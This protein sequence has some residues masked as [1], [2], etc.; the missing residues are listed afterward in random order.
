MPRSSIVLVFIA[1]LS[2]A[3]NKITSPDSTE[4]FFS[5]DTILFDTVF[6]SIGSTTKELRV[7]NRGNG[8]ITLNRILLAG[9]Q[10]SQFRLNIDGEATF[11]KGNVEIDPGD[12]I[13]IFVDV[14]VDPS[15]KSSPIAVTDSIVFSIKNEIRKVQ[16]LAWGQDIILINSMTIGTETWHKGKPYVVYNNVV[17]DT[18]ETLT[19]DAGTRIYFH[20]NSS[21]IIAGNILVNGSADL[22]VLFGS[23]RL[24]KMYEDVPGQWKGIFVLN[25]SKGNNINH[26]VI[27]NTIYGI[28][29]GEPVYSTDIPE[30]KLYSSFI[31][32]S[33]I[34]GLSAMTGK[35]QAANCLIAH[36]GNYCLFLSAGGEF[37]FTQCTLF[38]RWDY[39]LRL[40]SLLYVEEKPEQSNALISPLKLDFN[41][42]TIYGDNTSEIDIIPA[43]NILTSNYYFD[44]C[45]IKLDTLN[46][47]FW[48]RSDFPGTLINRNP[49]FLDVN[50]YDFRPD[51][52][53]PLIENGNPVYALEYPFDIR[54]ISRNSAQ[55]DIGAFERVPGERKED[56]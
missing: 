1:L 8:R 27:R 32:H 7:I 42:C 29:M 38:N 49:L 6:S 13:F 17:I 24:E 33:T 36:C 30:L 2:F 18:A 53:S 56:R 15:D 40:T 43:N 44:H 46:A 10:A 52:L 20:R 19:V 50:Q 45:L 9:G 35:I 12:S 22:N 28:Q 31:M 41:N 3:C 55:P 23:D 39:G 5:S 14:K 4:L 34:S 25:T 47:K 37:K 11:E 21:M 54:G 26:A 51:S 16:L 48:N